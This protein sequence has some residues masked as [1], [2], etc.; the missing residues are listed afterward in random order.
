LKLPSQM[1][2]FAIYNCFLLIRTKNFL[3]TVLFPITSSCSDQCDNS[4][5]FC[6][7]LHSSVYRH[8]RCIRMHA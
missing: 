5:L 2:V 1:L 7:T 8:G 3:E 6:K 4:I